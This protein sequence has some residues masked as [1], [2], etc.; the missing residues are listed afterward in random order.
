MAFRTDDDGGRRFD[1][2]VTADGK[3]LRGDLLV[4]SCGVSPRNELATLAG[5]RTAVGIV[6][7]AHLAVWSDPHVFAIG[8]C[9][10]VVERTD[11]LRRASA[12]CRAP[13]PG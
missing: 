13:R 2:L 7:D 9:A 10:Q 11:E 12:C 8:D 4:L 5:L 1:M 6:V 3:Q